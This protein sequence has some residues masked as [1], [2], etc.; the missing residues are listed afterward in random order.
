MIS[1]YSLIFFF[2]FLDYGTKSETKKNQTSLKSLYRVCVGHGKIWKMMF[3]K[4]NK[5]S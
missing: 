4:K 1:S 2:L 5:I 3:I